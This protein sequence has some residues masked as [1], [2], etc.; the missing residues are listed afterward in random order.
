MSD[1]PE[2]RLSLSSV[3]ETALYFR[4]QQRTER[5]YSGVLGMRLLAREEGRSL[6]Y[7]IGD[8]MLLLFQVDATLRGGSLPPH[9]ATGSTHVCFRCEHAAY[10]SWKRSLESHGVKLLQ[11]TEWQRGLSFYFH[12]PDGNLLEIA[13]ADIWPD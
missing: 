1:T 5:F 10:E 3:L 4:E 13:N 9:G 2:R 8:S 6:F 7:R 12:D 11:E